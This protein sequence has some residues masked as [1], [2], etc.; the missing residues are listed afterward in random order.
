MNDAILTLF[1]RGGRWVIAAVLFVCSVLQ[2]HDEC[3]RFWEA[4]EAGSI[5][6]LAKRSFGVTGVC[7][8]GIDKRGR[9]LGT[10]GNA[11][12]TSL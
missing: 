1:V 10:G 8:F 7:P 6:V 11:S 4:I 3:F 9:G 2:D 5:P 12:S